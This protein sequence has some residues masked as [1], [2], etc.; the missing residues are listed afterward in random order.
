MLYNRIYKQAQDIVPGM[1]LISATMKEEIDSFAPPIEVKCVY[2]ELVDNEPMYDFTVEGP[3]NMLIPIGIVKY[4]FF[5]MVCVHNSSIYGTMEPLA[6]WFKCKVPLIAPKGNWGTLMGDGP[7]A[8]RYTEAGLS[9]FGM[10]CVIGELKDTDNT[11]D[12]IP[13]YDRKTMEPEYLPVKVPLLLINGTFGIGVGM[14]VNIPPH[15]LVEVINETRAVIRDPNHEVVLVPDHCM[16]CN[17]IETDFREICRSGSGRYRVRGLVDTADHNGEPAIIVRSLPDGITTDVV[18]SKLL[19]LVEKK[20]LPMIKDISDA[21]TN[22]GVEIIIQLKKGSDVGYVKEVLYAKTKVQDTVSV[23]FMVV[24]GVN[25]KRMSYTEYIQEFLKLRATTKFRLYCNKLQI[26]LTRYHQLIAYIKLLESGEIDNVI[27]MVRKQNHIDDE[28]LIEYLIKKVGVTDLQAKFILGTDIRK[29]SKG[30]L[31]KYKAEFNELVKEQAVYEKAV[32]DDGTLIMSEIDKELEEIANKYGKPRV[33]KV[34]KATDDN[35]IPRGTFKVVIT[36]GNYVRKIP[37]TD[38]VGI[39]RKDNPK[40]ILRVDNAENILI[41]DNKGKVFKLPVY[42]IPVTDKSSAGTDIRV[43][44]K[45]LTAN[46]ISVL[47]EPVLKKIAEGPRKHYLTVVTKNNSIKKLDIEDFLTVNVS[48]LMYSKVA[49]D[50]EVA[51]VALVPIDLDVIIYSGHKALRCTT[52]SLPLFKRNAAGSKAMNT[53]DFIGGLSVIYPDANNIVVITNSGKINR[54]PSEGL[55]TTDRA[56]GGSAVIKLDHSDSI[57]SIYGV[58]DNDII[59][60]VTSDGVQ[61]IHV[62]DVPLGSSVMKGTKMINLKSCN[63][64]RTDILKGIG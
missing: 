34:I 9:E 14:G 23:N 13:N 37:D 21:S 36:E 57:F 59:R 15:N 43:L 1:K 12:W 46:V 45:N 22:N 61:E 18:V 33:C 19:D 26:N 10:D 3:E 42:K 39:V 62:S 32:T 4:G 31:N 56:K 6:N 25:P 64:I 48:G 44:Q 28:Y 30:Y 51:D 35:N 40:F 50:D 55:A 49:D 52:K 24:H 47:Y 53:K 8:M 41:F 7:A 38:K 20:Q 27:D 58:S 60:V 16:P 11:V 29:L 2:I 54:F 17:I 5:P 63:I